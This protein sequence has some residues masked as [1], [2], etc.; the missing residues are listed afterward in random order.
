MEIEFGFDICFSSLT[1]VYIVLAFCF[2]CAIVMLIST[3]A[4]I[5]KAVKKP[6]EEVIE[7]A[8][9]EI[10]DRTEDAIAFLENIVN[11]FENQDEYEEGFTH[12]VEMIK[13]YF[14]RKK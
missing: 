2:I 13:L 11:T 7:K 14:R 6:K 1:V 8:K 10:A 3:I 9:E 12:C 5:V 4:D